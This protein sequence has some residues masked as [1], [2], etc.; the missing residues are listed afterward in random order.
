MFKNKPLTVYG[1]QNLFVSFGFFLI[2]ISLKIWV[3]GLPYH[4]DEMAYIIP[5]ESIARG[6]LIEILPGYYPPYKFFGHPP[7][8]YVTVAGFYHIFR[9]DVALIHLVQLSFAFIGVFSTFLLGA[10][11]YNQSVGIFSALFLFFTPIYFTQSPMILSDIPVTSMIMVCLLLFLK[12]RPYTFV[13]AASYL[14][15]MKCTSLAFFFA[16]GVYVLG[17]ERNRRSWPLDLVIYALVPLLMGTAFMILQKFVYGQFVTNPFFKD[18]TLFDISPVSVFINFAKVTGWITFAQHRWVL[19]ILVITWIVK[20]KKAVW[21]N[22]FF[23]F[24]TIVTCFVFTFSFIYALPRYLLPCFPFFCILA[25]AALKELFI[26]ER[27]RWICLVGIILLFATDF[28]GFGNKPN[29]YSEDLQYIDIVQSHK[30]AV[31]FVTTEY[32]GKTIYAEWP[33]N[34]AF[35]IPFLGYTKQPATIVDDPREAEVIVYTPQ[36]SPANR[37]LKEVIDAL[38]LRKITRF[39]RNRKFVEIYLQ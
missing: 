36:G 28:Y 1:R 18:H 32:Q 10:Q 3:V 27:N 12:K 8:Y 13:V 33:L 31:H 19:S 35:T 21:K 2:M 29:G 39:E 4:W 20:K 22:E 25:A 11:L 14:T 5:A 37:E 26:S 17:F 9:G 34:Q 15:L 16:L 30:S 24:G 38:N 7:G 23:L 6:R